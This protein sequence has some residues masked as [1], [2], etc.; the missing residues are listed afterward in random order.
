MM[1]LD[2][3]ALLHHLATV[4]HIP[5]NVRRVVIDAA[6]DDV[7]RVYYECF[8]DPKLLSVEALEPVK[9]AVMIHVEDLADK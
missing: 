9:D 5:R 8:G 2:G 4:C 6:V 1:V 7:V 3:R